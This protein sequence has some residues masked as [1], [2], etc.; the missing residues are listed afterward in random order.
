[1]TAAE[2]A[3]KESFLEIA[4]AVGMLAVRYGWPL[5]RLVSAAAS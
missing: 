4:A 1:V 2:V 3:P 5:E